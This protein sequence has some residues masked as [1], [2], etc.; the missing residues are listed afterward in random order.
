VGSPAFCLSSL[1]LPCTFYDCSFS[2]RFPQDY[3]QE[4]CSILLVLRFV[5]FSG[6]AGASKATRHS[7][8][9]TRWRL[10]TD[11]LPLESYLLRS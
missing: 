7:S 11:L 3:A 10:P 8:H 9:S 2:Q 5:F 1:V 6:L 4:G